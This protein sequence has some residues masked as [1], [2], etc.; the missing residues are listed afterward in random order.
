MELVRLL[1]VELAEP[2]WRPAM[3]ND[4]KDTPE[5]QDEQDKNALEE[6]QEQAAEEREEEGGYQ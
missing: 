1:P 2:P 6:A 4:P 5:E 3:A